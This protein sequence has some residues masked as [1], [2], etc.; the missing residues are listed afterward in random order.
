MQLTRRELLDLLEELDNSRSE[1]RDVRATPK[2]AKPFAIVAQLPSDSEFHTTIS[3]QALISHLE[4]L[5]ST[6]YDRL[7][8]IGVTNP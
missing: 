4:E 3:R 1:L 8:E 7:V 5:V 2:D 6:L